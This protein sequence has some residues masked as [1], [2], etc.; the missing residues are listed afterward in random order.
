MSNFD[1][2]KRKLNNNFNHFNLDN[3]QPSVYKLFNLQHDMIQTLLIVQSLKSVIPLIP[4]REN[5]DPMSPFV[6]SHIM[7]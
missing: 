5:G 3:Q 1:L 4:L 6:Q 7:K 2:E